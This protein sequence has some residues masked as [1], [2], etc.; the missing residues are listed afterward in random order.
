MAEELARQV[1][2]LDPLAAVKARG[3]GRDGSSHMQPRDVKQVI[4]ITCVCTHTQ[5]HKHTHNRERYRENRDK[6][7]EGGHTH[8][9]KAHTVM[10]ASLKICSRTTLTHLHMG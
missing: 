1:K 8:T 3:D 6:E 4:H 9:P 2:R 5:P 7:R 10:N